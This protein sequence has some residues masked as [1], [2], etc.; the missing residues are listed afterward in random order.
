MPTV[1]AAAPATWMPLTCSVVDLGPVTTDRD[2]LATV[3]LSRRHEPDGAVVVPVVVPVH[4]CRHPGAG[5]FIAEEG[6]SGIIRSVFDGAEQRFREGVVIAD[7]APGEGSEYSQLLQP[8]L[9]G[10]GAHGIA[11]VGMED[12]GLP[13]AFADPF[14]EAGPA[15]QIGGDLSVFPLGHL[16]GH[17]LAAPDVDHQVKIQLHPPHAGGQVGDVPTPELIRPPGFQPR[18]RPWRLGR[19]GPTAAVGLSMGMEHPVEAALGSEIQPTV[20]QNWHDLAR[21]QCRELR[22]IAG[23]QD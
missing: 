20:G 16:P 9:D 4:E 5:L 12:Q 6:P 19:A 1:S 15:H 3:A 13:A 18:H 14:L 23:E 17:H 7:P 10:G 22:L 21:R 2:G 8:D 11:V